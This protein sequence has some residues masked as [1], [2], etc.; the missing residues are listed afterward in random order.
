M[1]NNDLTNQQ[2]IDILKREFKRQGEYNF[3]SSKKRAKS[4]SEFGKLQMLCDS[5][6]QAHIGL[7]LKGI[8]EKLSLEWI[9]DL[10]NN[11]VNKS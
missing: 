3:R 6:A 5:F 10:K 2:I 4:Y 1:S 7:S 8:A 9:E 11:Q